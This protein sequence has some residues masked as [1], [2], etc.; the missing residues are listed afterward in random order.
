[1]V[2]VGLDV[3]VVVV[4]FVDVVVVVVV[5]FVFVALDVF[6]DG[7]NRGSLKVVVLQ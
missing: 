4:V 7:F 1:M 6:V 3:G 5:V 2:F